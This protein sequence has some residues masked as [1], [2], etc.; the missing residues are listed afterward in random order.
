MISLNWVKDYINLDNIDLNDLAKNITE[1]GINVENI[2]THHINNLV[3]GEVLSCVNHPSSDHLHLCEV[4]VGSEV[5]K[6]VCGAPNVR[7]GIKVIVAKIGA[8]LPGDFEIKKST[9]R[10]EESNGMLC[11]LY[12][13]GLEEKTDETYAKGICEL[14]SDAQ[15]G[16]DPLRYLGFDDTLY[17]LDVHK[18]RNNDC[19]YHIGFAYEIGTILNKKVSLPDTSYKVSKEDINKLYKLKVESSKVPLYLGKLV[20]NVTIKESPEWIKRRLEACNMRSI[21]NVVD[22]S[23]YVMLEYGQPTHFFDADK[24]GTNIVVRN[25]LD[26]EKIITLDNQQR[27]LNVSDLVITDGKEAVCLAG[28]MGGLDSEVTNSTKNIFVESAIFDGVTIRNTSERLDL[29]SE[30]SIRYGKGLNYEYTYEAMNRCC[31]LLEKYADATITDGILVHDT[32]NK[33]PKKVSF[34]VN[35]INSLLGIT[36]SKEDMMNELDRLDFKYVLK[37]DLFDVTIPNRRIDIEPNVA[38]MAEEIIRLY[39]YNNLKS[40]LPIVSTK[41]GVYKED[42]KMRKAI[43]KR[44]RSLGINETRTYNLVSPKMASMFKYNNVQNKVLPNPMSVDKSVLRTTLIPS[45][46]NVYSYNK[47]RKVE[48]IMLYECSETFDNNYKR[49]DKVCILM[50]GN[51]LSNQVLSVKIPVDF[52]VIKGV[53]ESILDYLGFKNRYSYK[54]LDED[55]DF[56]PGIS[57]QIL[58]DR[59]PVGVVGKVHPRISKDNIFVAELSITKLFNYKIKPLKYKQTSKYPEIKKDVAFIVDND[60]TNEEI[61]N[62]IKKSGGRLLSNIEIFD[63]YKDIEDGKKSMAYTLT[64]KDDTRTLEDKEVMDIFHNII[65]TVEEK[66]HAKLRDS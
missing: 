61:K 22:I 66:L 3:I 17:E 15:V 30:A 23:N 2:I 29:K 4:N 50:K 35:D 64:F 55:C 5:L 18:H 27:E 56:H 42:I 63:I 32:I 24:L 57:A 7:K 26:N 39:G 34:T 46:L 60:I 20:K 41:R 45:L 51:L 33:E 21:N 9:I 8:V 38:D 47:A 31:N 62:I 14:S 12:E 10:G 37:D 19:Y 1:K 11:A 28:I 36:I 40:T 13:L 53:V 59:E 65:S 49:D 52:Y 44:L 48:D 16:E 25:A 43:S 54:L 6:I 58:I